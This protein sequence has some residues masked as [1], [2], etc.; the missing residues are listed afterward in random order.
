[1]PVSESKSME[2]YEPL[3]TEVERA[4]LVAFL[5]GY[6]GGTREAYTLDLRQFTAW[7]V[8][9]QRHLFDARRVDI[10]MFARSLEDSGRARATVAPPVVHGGRV[11]PVRR[12]RRCADSG[13]DA[14]AHPGGHAPRRERGR[15]AV[16]RRGA[17]PTARIARARLK[18]T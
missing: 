4:T 7:C 14:D 5:A 3:L 18:P 17:S 2:R 15:R 13:V 12:R 1:M 10:E 6:R 8:Q 16:R 11:L 9:H